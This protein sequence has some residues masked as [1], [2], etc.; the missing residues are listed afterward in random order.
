MRLAACVERI[1]ARD[2]ERRARHAVQAFVRGRGDRGDAAVVEIDRFGAEAADAIEQQADAA[3]AAHARQRVEVVQAAGRRLVMDDRDV[4]ERAS[5]RAA[6]DDRVDVRRLHPLVLRRLRASMP[7]CVA[8]C[9]MRS[10]YTPFSTTSSRPPSGTSA[11]IML[12][13][14]AVPEPVI[15]TALQ[16]GGIELVSGEQTRARL[17]LQIEELAARDGTSRFAAGSAHAFAQRDRTRIEQQ[18]QRPPMLM[19]CINARRTSSGVIVGRGRSPGVPVADR[20]PRE[21]RAVD[22]RRVEARRSIAPT[23]SPSSASA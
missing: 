11:A 20:Q 3:L 16:Y 15:S 8:I 21:A 6:A 4:R 13:T 12:S 1:A 10:P 23:S 2:D 17:V 19:C 14:A 5:R 9:A 18:H 22:V 7:Y